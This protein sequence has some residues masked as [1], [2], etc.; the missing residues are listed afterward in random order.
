MPKVG[1]LFMG[2]LFT[3]AA[4]S[5]CARPSLPEQKPPEEATA[6]ESVVPP[7]D[8]NTG[9][10]ITSPAFID[11]TNIP[12]KYTCD[13]QNVS[14]ALTWRQ[15]PAGTTSFAL[16]LEDP[17]APVKNFTHW[18]IFNFLPDTRGLSEAIPRE[19]TLTGGALQGENGGGVIG[20]LGPCPP[21]GPAH[22]Y[23]FNLYALD[24]SLDLAV[25]ATKDQVRQA[26]EGHILGRAQLVG[27]YQR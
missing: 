1:F 19:G 4:V 13:G 6:P 18:L 20:Y 2:L 27:L 11:G 12:V 9:F 23:I 5:G 15:G 22:H 8:S 14:P 26:M 24:K 25:G 16:I 17:D 3:L 7:E 10:S 21:K